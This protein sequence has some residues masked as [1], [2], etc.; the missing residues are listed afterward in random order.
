VSA[1]LREGFKTYLQAV[2]RS[3]A[4]VRAYVAVVDRWLLACGETG[5]GDADTLLR[6]LAIRRDR[7][8]QASM[9][10]EVSGLKAWFK[11]LRV[12]APHMWQP[13]QY[14]KQMR[15]HRRL[16]RALTDVE[17]GMLLAAPDLST[18]VGL[19][20]H[21]I[22]ATLYQCGLRA[23]ELAGLEL[24]SVRLDGYLLVRGKGDKE[25]LV[26]YGGEWRTLLD[27]YLAVRA[28]SG[29]GKRNA[30]F[31]TQHG[32]ALRDGRSVWVIVNRY[33]RA[34]LGTACGYTRLSHTSTSRP[35]RGHYPHMLR[36]SYATEL[37]KAGVNVMNLAQLLGHVDASTTAHYV[38]VD[39][40]EL[41]TAVGHHPRAA[42]I[43]T[44]HS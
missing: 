11:W 39:L 37:N 7:V 41:R 36:A 5:T 6:Y 14:P 31:V 27:Q 33:A 19:R 20:D 18:F 1:P 9:N 26:P 3:P 12:A 38:A 40:K 8:G 24:G 13:G 21:V 34:A 44:D 10:M 22:I 28:T 29:C 23:S 4:T 42:R 15:L 43:K 25:R 17:V 30:L 16:V 35:W 32:K 2:R